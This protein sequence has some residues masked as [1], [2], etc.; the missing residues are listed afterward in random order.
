MHQQLNR[1]GKL[2]KQSVPETEVMLELF[3][4]T[5]ETAKCKDCGKGTVSISRMSDEF[6]DLATRR[7]NV[8]NQD[9]NP[10]RVEIFPAVETCTACADKITSEKSEDDYCARCGERM[11]LVSTNRRG[12]TQYVSRCNGCGYEN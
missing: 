11:S 1:V 10:E 5:T 2:L 9:I 6:D 12:I 8:C 7:C 4:T 3:R